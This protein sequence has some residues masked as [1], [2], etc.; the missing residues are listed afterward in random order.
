MKT[1]M[2]IQVALVG[3]MALLATSCFSTE[4]FQTKYD[5]HTV[6]G[7]EPESE[8]EWDDFVDAW[9]NRGKDTVFVYPSMRFGPVYFFAK[10]DDQDAFQGGMS[11]CRGKDADASPEREPSYFAVY[12]ENVGNQRSHAY[13]VFHQ[14]SASRMPE[15]FIQIYIPNTESSCGAESMYVHN[16]QAVVQAVQHGVGL[17]GGPFQTDDYLLL[18]VTGKR[19][20]SVT[21]TKEVKLV[22]GT[23]FIKEWTKVDITDL[24]SVDTIDFELT[25][26]RQDLPLYCCLDDLMVHYVEIY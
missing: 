10:L 26:S 13:A 14:A 21:G 11:L 7:F 6:V 5:S 16:V 19:G 23:S 9:F 15:H 8:Y 24:G 17:A 22:D 2:M 1:K 25:S 12:D 20:T 3:V 4:D 18:T